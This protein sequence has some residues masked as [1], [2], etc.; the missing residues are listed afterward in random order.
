MIARPESLLE[1]F[2]GFEV[3][4]ID[5]Q[6]VLAAYAAGESF[7]PAWFDVRAVID[8]GLRAN[9]IAAGE[10][11]RAAKALE[12][13]CLH[14]GRYAQNIAHQQ[15]LTEKQQ[16]LLLTPTVSPRPLRRVAPADGDT[17]VVDALLSVEPDAS[18]A[19]GLWLTDYPPMVALPRDGRIRLDIDRGS[20]ERLT[21]RPEL[22]LGWHPYCRVLARYRSRDVPV[23]TLDP[24]RISLRVPDFTLAQLRELADEW[25]GGLDNHAFASLVER[26]EMLDNV[27]LPLTQLKESL[28]STT[29]L[30]EAIR[31]QLALFVEPLEGRPRGGAISRVEAFED[32]LSGPLA[33][34]L[35][36][37]FYRSLGARSGYA[38][39]DSAISAKCRRLTQPF[40]NEEWLE[41]LP[42]LSALGVL[43]YGAAA[44]AALGVDVARER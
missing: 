32:D 38:H 23:P 31:A 34:W 37:Y 39:V 27:L 30:E 20:A 24:L 40:D 22:V 26:K 36:A 35:G 10:L 19:P 33:F 9:T 6:N 7:R 17:V 5:R 3:I 42:L 11:A 18:E 44:L 43:R 8:H 15:S 28:P 29:T 21:K 25:D 1:S 13:R 4:E 14:D 2:R 41:S 12:M 16:K